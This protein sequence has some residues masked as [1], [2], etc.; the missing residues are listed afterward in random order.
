MEKQNAQATEPVQASQEEENRGFYQLEENPELQDV[1]RLLDSDEVRAEGSF[2]ERLIL[3]IL[4]NINAAKKKAESR[5]ANIGT[6]GGAA[7]LDENGK[8]PADQLPSMDY[9]PNSEKNAPGGV[10]TL[11]EDGKIPLDQFP[12]AGPGGL[13]GLDDEG[14]IPMELLHT[15]LGGYEGEPPYG[16][17]AYNVNGVINTHGISIITDGS[18][19]DT[20]DEYGFNGG[21][22]RTRGGSLHT[23]GGL[24]STDGGHIS[25]IGGNFST[26]TNI[27]GQKGG[28]IET[29][30]G[31]I[32]TGGGDISTGG[33]EISAGSVDIASGGSI[34]LQGRDLGG[35]L[36]YPDISIKC[37]DSYL[38]ISD[39]N[40]AV[41]LR[42]IKAPTA[43]DG[44][45]NK[46]YADSAFLPKTGGSITG[47]LELR[48][49]GSDPYITIA[50]NGASAGSASSGILS[51]WSGSLGY[52]TILRGL[53]TPEKDYDAVPKRYVDTTIRAGIYT[54]NGSN[55]QQIGWNG[56]EGQKVKAVLVE[57][58]NGSRS[59]SVY[60]GIA[61]PNYPLQTSSGTVCLQVLTT[62]FDVKGS[63]NASGVRYYYIAFF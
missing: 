16:V 14:K 56:G 9:I 48:S 52:G 37:T 2:F 1:E 4:N 62:A 5:A 30:G 53:K 36:K 50:H 43:S 58:I 34:L 33:G 31:N 45:V 24:I 46:A 25:T 63:L 8:V 49:Q 57:R 21:N 55:I 29:S 41:Q 3:R 59:T 44:A 15:S 22:I 35:N 32:D 47:S 18:D 7:P 40:S 61:F 27:T 60:G 12:G 11:D 39:G 38:K 23:D 6:P 20:G 51:I 28:N 19:I 54:G 17:L 13:A 10:P 42:G 26:S